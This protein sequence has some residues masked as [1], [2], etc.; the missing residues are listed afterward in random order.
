MFVC[1]MTNL[2]LKLSL[3]ICLQNEIAKFSMLSPVSKVLGAPDGKIYVQ[4]QI[5]VTGV[6]VTQQHLH[7]IQTINAEFEASF[8]IV[9]T[10]DSSFYKCFAAFGPTYC[11]GSNTE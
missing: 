7:I 1:G 6:H 5:L 4:S 11:T 2:R 3:L 10:Y 8:P 9:S